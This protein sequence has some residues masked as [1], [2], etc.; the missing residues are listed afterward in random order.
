MK[1]LSALLAALTAALRAFPLW[2]A[3]KVTADCEALTTEILHH[4]S[5][6][7]PASRARA[8][9]LRIALAYRR[10]L[11][12]TLLAGHPGTP[13]GHPGGDAPGNL[14]EPD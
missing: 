5:T 3:W 10:K 6:A 1:T 4:E 9:E 8:D 11:Y 2:L 12:A 13:G 7:T 14:S